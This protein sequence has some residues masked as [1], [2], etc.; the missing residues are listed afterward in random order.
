MLAANLTICIDNADPI[1][2]HCIVAIHL[3]S[4]PDQPGR[5]QIYHYIKENRVE[6][7]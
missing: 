7:I 4:A 2:G 1:R 6:K 5:K 3:I